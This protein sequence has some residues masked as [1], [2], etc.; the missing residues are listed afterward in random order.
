VI[1]KD[2][3]RSRG[4]AAGRAAHTV[5][6]RSVTDGEDTAGHVIHIDVRIGS[7]LGDP[8]IRSGVVLE[9]VSEV[10]ARG[11]R[12]ASTHGIEAPVSWEEDAHGADAG[13]GREVSTGRPTWC[14]GWSR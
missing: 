3:C 2:T 13:D 1:A 9:G 5:D 6:L 4:P 8:G 14:A 11:V 10:V 12:A 7:D